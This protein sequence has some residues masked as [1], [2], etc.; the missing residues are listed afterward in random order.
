MMNPDIKITILKKNYSVEAILSTCT[1]L[2]QKKGAFFVQ[3]GEDGKSYEV[4][5]SRIGNTDGAGGDE[6]ALRALAAEFETL[7]YD[8]QVRLLLSKNNQESR[9]Q[10]VF[11]AISNPVFFEEERK[12]EDIPESIRKILEEDAGESDESYLD[13]PLQIAVPWEESKT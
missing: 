1:E 12:E 10:I 13:D 5:I 7:L 9:E 2:S 3:P 6:P 11:N 8:N 4:L